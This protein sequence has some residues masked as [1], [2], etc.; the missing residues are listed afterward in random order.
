[1]TQDIAELR[2]LAIRRAALRVRLGTL[3]RCAHPPRTVAV[4]MAS[5]IQETERIDAQIKR[6]RAGAQPGQ[7]RHT[8]QETQYVCA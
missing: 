6:L 8:D 3:A 5:L 4:E 1:M 2:A 7:R